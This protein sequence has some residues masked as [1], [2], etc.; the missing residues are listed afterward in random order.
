MT[1]DLESRARRAVEQAGF[2]TDFPAAQ[3]EMQEARQKLE[4][5]TRSDEVRDTRDWLWSSIDND[6]SR[7]LDQ[8][9]VAQRLPNGDI[10]VQ[11]GIA[12]V[13]E[14]VP[15]GSPLDERAAR[16]TVSVYTG[17]ETF[18]MLPRQLSE[19]LTSLLPDEDRLAIV[20]AFSVQADGA[21]RDIEIFRAIIRNHAK[22][23]YEEVGA[24]L[25][26]ASSTRIAELEEVAGLREQITLQNEAAVRLQGARERAG[27]L[28][29]ESLEVTP[30]MQNGRVVE[31]RTQR[32][33]AAR[34]II[35]NFM[36]CS[37]MAM[38]QFLPDHG[39]SSLAR[40][41]RQP[42]RWPRIRE[43][44]ANVGDS[45]PE[46]AD[47]RALSSFLERRKKAAPDD[48]AQLS[49]SVVKLL[50]PGTYELVR[51]NDHEGHFGLGAARY[52]HSTA[53]NRRYPDLITQRLI[54]AAL[55]NQPAPYSDD[56]LASI[57]ERC[58]ERESAAQKVERLMR[59]VAAA[60]LFGDRIGQVFRGVVTGS[61]AKGVWVRVLDP[62][63]EGR[64]VRGEEGLDV[65]EQVRVRLL[66]TDIERGFIDF[67][68][69]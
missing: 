39:R 14:L 22:L 47:P 6:T 40:V 29:L 35:E 12:D 37:N 36:V 57:A 51:P 50:G 31:L 19:D 15:Q 33:N 60:A 49:L 24:W 30:V 55:T 26:D 34:R 4:S 13:D 9:E 69:A 7:D 18:P 5:S 59:K 25:D 44:A 10:R 21:L 45:L 54:K 68:R 8:V 67:A 58:N 64:V 62:P 53:P 61:S 56:E 27:A 38:A 11:I 46:E 32:K 20:V 17:V 28:D 48:Y 63:V 1:L 66:D 43:I 16:N 23:I 2:E 65:G 42:E 41:V 52:T 3:N